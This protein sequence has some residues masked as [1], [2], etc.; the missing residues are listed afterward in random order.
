[1]GDKNSPGWGSICAQLCFAALL[2]LTVAQGT[3]DS[4]VRMRKGRTHCAPSKDFGAT[5]WGADGRCFAQ[6]FPWAG[7][8][9][10][11]C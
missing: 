9:D 10:S 2:V 3:G 5:R 8:R 1:M 6:L 7:E 11:V 4:Q